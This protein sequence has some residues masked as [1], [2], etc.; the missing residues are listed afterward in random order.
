MKYFQLRCEQ[1]NWVHMWYL[2]FF[3]WH[4]LTRSKSITATLLVHSLIIACHILACQEKSS[5]NNNMQSETVY[6]WKSLSWCALLLQKTVNHLIK[7]LRNGKNWQIYH[8]VN[9]LCYHFQSTI[10][11]TCQMRVFL[12]PANRFLLSILLLTF[13]LPR[14]KLFCSCLFKPMLVQTLAFKLWPR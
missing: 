7:C 11:A 10:E 5:L 13:S 6:I 14:H 9:F 12:S 3:N 4:I 1:K 8:T 2:L